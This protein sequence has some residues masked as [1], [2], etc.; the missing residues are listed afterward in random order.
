MIPDIGE[1]FAQIIFSQN[2]DTAVRSLYNEGIST[3]Q[4][5]SDLKPILDLL[6]SFKS[7][8]QSETY[9]QETN[10]MS[11][12]VSNEISSKI[13]NIVPNNIDTSLSVYILNL[14]TDIDKFIQ[15]ESIDEDRIEEIGCFIYSLG[16]VTIAEAKRS[17]EQPD[18]FLNI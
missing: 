3:N 10:A 13:F 12:L 15:G 16:N 4:R 11:Q 7:Q 2:C 9:I 1:R 6:K 8:L 18:P 5:N 17:L 14:V